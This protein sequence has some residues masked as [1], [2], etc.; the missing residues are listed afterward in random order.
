MTSTCDL[1]IRSKKHTRDAHGVYFLLTSLKYLL[2][3]DDNLVGDVGIK[4]YFEEYRKYGT[5]PPECK[6]CHKI[7]MEPFVGLVCFRRYLHNM[8]V[9]CIINHD[10]TRYCVITV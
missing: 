1:D 4:S 7:H 2:S 10:K 9:N 5:P 3:D 6:A 8:T